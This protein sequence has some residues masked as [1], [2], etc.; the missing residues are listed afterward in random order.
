MGEEALAIARPGLLPTGSADAR[1]FPAVG[2]L[3]RVVRQLAGPVLL[4]LLPVLSA[5]GGTGLRGLDS[6]DC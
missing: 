5:R 3:V 1:F 2:S 4:V 6:R